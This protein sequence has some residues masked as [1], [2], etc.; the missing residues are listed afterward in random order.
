MFK[1][2]HSKTLLILLFFVL[3]FNIPI[4]IYPQDTTEQYNVSEN[5]IFNKIPPLNTLIDSAIQNNPL[6]SFRD[7]QIIVNRCKLNA[8]QSNW[9]RNLGVQTDVRYGTFNIFST[10]TAEGKTPDLTATQNEQMNYGVGVYLKFPIQDFVNRKNQIN[11]AKAEISQAES[12]AQSQRKEVRQLVITQ[13]NDLILKKKLLGIRSRYLETTK[14][15]MEMA[16]KEFRNGIIPISEFTRISEISVRS[17]SDFETARID[18]ITAYLILE[19][20]VGMKFNQ[21]LNTTK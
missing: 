21:N 11:M 16:D 2:K 7:L 13:Y 17:E 5:D 10:N 1:S 18:F 6:V 12:M 15:S 4:H 3:L 19:E 20:I 9:M 14:I 8:E